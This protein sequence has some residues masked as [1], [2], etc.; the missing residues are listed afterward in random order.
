MNLRSNGPSDYRAVTHT[1]ALDIKFLVC[2]MRLLFHAFDFILIYCGLASSEQYFIFIKI[3]SNKLCCLKKVALHGTKGMLQVVFYIQGAWIIQTGGTVLFSILR[4]GLGV[5]ISH[6]GE[7]RSVLG[8]LWK[9]KVLN[10]N[11]RQFLS[12]LQEFNS[13][14][15]YCIIK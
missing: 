5:V 1:T 8:S 3:T 4:S 14:F 12:S 6:I 13:F 15:A 11:E 10:Q 9:V 2:F 7:T